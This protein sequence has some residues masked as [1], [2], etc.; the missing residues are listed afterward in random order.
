MKLKRSKLVIVIVTLALVCALAFTLSACNN[1]G[2]NGNKRTPV[3]QGMTIENATKALAYNETIRS[4]PVKAIAG[5]FSGDY[6]GR[7]EN[8]DGNAPFD[9]SIEDAIDDSLKVQGSA[10]KIY[11]AVPNQDIY[12]TIHIDNPDS[13]EIMSFTLNGEKYSSYMFEYGSNMENIILKKNVGN[14]S[15]IVEYT[16][17]AIKYIDGTEIKDVLINGDQTVRAGVK[18]ANQVSASVQQTVDFDKI[19]LNVTVNDR[20]GLI[21]YSNG[22]VK[23]VLYDGENLIDEQDIT[24]GNNEVI[25][26]ELEI[27]TLYQYA[28][29]GYYDDLESGC[30]WNVIYKKAFYT[31]TIVLFDNIVVKQEGISFDFRWHAEAETNGIS[32]LRLIKDGNTQNLDVKTNSVN[33]LLSDNDYT[34]AATFE[35]NGKEREI[36]LDFHTLAK[37]VPTLSVT[38]KNITQTGFEF[39]IA[40]TDTDNVGEITKIERIHNGEATIAELSA[41]SFADLLSNNDYTVRVTYTYNLNDG[42]GAHTLVATATAHTIAKATPIV[43]VTTSNV[44]Q[45]GF[46]YSVAVTDTDSVGHLQSVEL[47]QGNSTIQTITAVSGTFSSLN[48]YTQYTVK[49]TYLYDLN[50]GAGEH[51]AVV[52]ETLYTLPV[53]DATETECINSYPVSEGE[54][55][56][57]Q[58]RVHNPHNANVTQV[59]VNGLWYDVDGTTTATFVRVQ[60][61]SVGQFA[62]G[63][64]LL[65]VE[66][67]RATLDNKEFIFNL[68]ANNEATCFVNG[69]ID[70]VKMVVVDA[71]G[72]EI[73][74]AYNTDTIYLQVTFD[75]PTGYTITALSVARDIYLNYR[76]EYNSEQIVIVDTN[77]VR[78]QIKSDYSHTYWTQYCLT[79]YSYSNAS[80]GT[81]T[82]DVENVWTSLAVLDG[83]KEVVEIKTAED[84]KNMNG[85][86]FYK[87]MN[88]ID[89]KDT[90][91]DSPANFSGVFDGDGHTIKNMRVVGLTFENRDVYLGLFSNATGLIKNLN[92]EDTLIIVT[93]N[94]G[95]CYYGGA[96][97]QALDNLTIDNVHTSGEISITCERFSQTGGIVGYCNTLNASQTII[98][99]S[100]NASNI[101]GGYNAGGIVGDIGYGAVINCYN[102]GNITGGYGVGGIVSSLGNGTITNCYNTGDITANN[103]ISGGIAGGIARGT[104]L[105]CYNTGTISAYSEGNGTPAIAGG[106]VGITHESLII[107]N[108]YNTGNLISSVTG[109]GG[110]AGGMVGDCFNDTVIILTNCF[111]V[112]QGANVNFN[113][114]E[115]GNYTYTDC[116]HYSDGTQGTKVNSVDE[117]LEKMREL[118]DEEIW[119]FD[120]TTDLGFPT[121]R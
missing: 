101:T 30:N 51:S 114:W 78:V 70:A 91:W 118:F 120:T 103:H 55:I 71:N 22:A 6:E 86:K 117:L 93:V 11:Y 10:Q 68:D 56:I 20:D 82:K 46:A 21:A 63:E 109:S 77:T 116:Y 45:T 23:A 59:K 98:T 95:N 4:A 54:M 27:S 57:L 92:I 42:T 99:N 9:E 67:A 38:T 17:D 28:I 58:I 89:L 112:A 47:L 74:Y 25:F 31:K 40:V 16:I 84:L 65:E 75:N 97:A 50:D 60:I 18:T 113:G 13:F 52:T 62:G 83:A 72:E 110:S 64:T 76:D 105:H 104:I 90:P 108:C 32:S 73:D 44:T 34:L 121:L 3:Y 66:S 14:T 69:N 96:V 85:G 29:V 106:I 102:T 48:T 39:D 53:F 2:G 8:V 36:K 43:S 49:V 5:G 88:D 1:K 80:V 111:Y 79:S 61:E 12:I 7:D 37:A 100:S 81:K 87:L 94:N 107:M 24:V 33:G 19:K 26:D 35:Y 115:Y 15:G 41:R 119:D